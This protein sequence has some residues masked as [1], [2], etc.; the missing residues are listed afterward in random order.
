MGFRLLVEQ[1]IEEGRKPYKQEV[2]RPPLKVR[3]NGYVGYIFTFK[4]DNRIRC[5]L[6][7]SIYITPK[8]KKSRYSLGSSLDDA[9]PRAKEIFDSWPT[10]TDTVRPG[11]EESIEFPFNIIKNGERVASIT[12]KTKSPTNGKSFEYYRVTNYTEILPGRENKTERRVRSYDK[13]LDIVFN[14][15][16]SEVKTDTDIPSEEECIQKGKVTIVRNNRVGVI[17]PFTSIVPYRY[18]GKTDKSRT[19]TYKYYKAWILNTKTIES[20]ALRY[21]N[22]NK[23]AYKDAV[24]WVLNKLKDDSLFP[25]LYATEPSHKGTLGPRYKQYLQKVPVNDGEYKYIVSKLITVNTIAEVKKKQTFH[26]KLH[27][28][29][30][31]FGVCANIL[32]KQSRVLSYVTDFLH[33]TRGKPMNDVIVNTQQE[34]ELFYNATVNNTADIVNTLLPTYPNALVYF[35]ESTTSQFNSDVRRLINAPQERTQVIPKLTFRDLQNQY[36]ANPGIFFKNL[37]RYPNN[38][39]GKLL[40]LILKTFLD[41]ELEDDVLDEKVSTTSIARYIKTMWEIGND[42]PST[43]PFRD[44][45][46]TGNDKELVKNISWLMGQIKG[47]SDSNQKRVGRGKSIP[48]SFS[49]FHQLPKVKIVQEGEPQTII[50]IDDNMNRGN[51]YEAINKNIIEAFGPGV[52]IIWAFGAGIEEKIRAYIE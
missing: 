50:L 43:N 8:G 49:V 26:D 21:I 35:A 36:N 39:Q 31:Y 47:P 25:S 10:L 38:P 37:F 40:T 3:G 20:R 24:D 41:L 22:N 18:K 45:R 9:I 17:T 13:A 46:L 7:I 1:I 27:N 28:I 32:L 11:S 33:L 29:T 2:D 48:P 30:L 4:S 15:R 23:V 5:I 52:N 6:D 14:T 42:D 12:K 44:I 34:R 16:D 51:T 19:Y